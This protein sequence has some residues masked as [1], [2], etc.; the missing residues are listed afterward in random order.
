MIIGH[1]K[2]F[3]RAA[4]SPG[5]LFKGACLLVGGISGVFL[6]AWQAQFAALMGNTPAVSL[7]VLLAAAITIAI[8]FRLKTGPAQDTKLL[9]VAGTLLFATATWAWAF[10]YLIQRIGWAAHRWGT[11]LIDSP[12]A[13]FT[14]TFCAALVALGIPCLALAK[15]W[16]I[17]AESAGSDAAFVKQAG[18]LQFVGYSRVPLAWQV[19]GFG[20][21]LLVAGC[22][23]AP[24]LGIQ[25]TAMTAAVFAGVAGL[26]CLWQSV[27]PVEFNSEATT[28]HDADVAPTFLTLN[29]VRVATWIAL[30]V[31]GLI[32]ANWLRMTGQLFL[33][34]AEMLCIAWGGI[35]LGLA[36]GVGLG[37]WHSRRQAGQSRIGV[38]ACFLFAA[39]AVCLTA[40]FP[41][42]VK[43]S[44]WMNAYQSS[45]FWLTAGRGGILW[46]FCLPAGLTWG[47][48][49]AAPALTRSTRTALLMKRFALIPAALG[50]CCYRWLDLPAL[51]P[52][53]LA[54]CTAGLLWLAAGIAAVSAGSV[55]AGW[56]RRGIMLTSLAVI[57]ISPVWRTSYDP[58]LAAR[59]LFSTEIFMAY[60]SKFAIDELSQF[61]DARLHKLVEGKQGTYTLWKRRG[62][63]WQIRENGLSSTV[64]P[65]N[66]EL[67]PQ[68]SAEVL[69][70]I[71]PFLMHEHPETALFLGM[72]GSGALSSSLHFPL[73]EIVCVEADGAY[74]DL[75]QNEILP[76]T[77]ENPL[78]DD[79]VSVRQADPA[80]LA[81]AGRKLYDVIV[82]EPGYSS[83]PHNSAYFTAE[84]YQN[85]AN[86]LTADGIFAQ[87]F[88]YIDYGAEPLRVAA[89]TLSQA[90]AH[91]MFLQTAAGEMLLL[92]SNS[93]AGLVRPGLLARVDR[94]HVQAAL[95]GCGWDWSIVLNLSTHSQEQLTEFVSETPT[96]A[97][98]I[99]GGHFHCTLPREVI[100]W[101]NKMQ[102]VG[103]ALMPRTG[104]LLDQMGDDAGDPDVLE[105]LAEVTGKQKLIRDYPDQ[106]W[107][108]RSSVREQVTAGASGRSVIQQVKHQLAGHDFHP[109]DQR[110]MRYFAALG[111]AQKTK[112]P[113]DI[114]QLENFAFP[115]D[116]MITYFLHG[117]AAEL[118]SRA[119]EQRVPANELRH[120]LYST[121]YS[122]AGDRSV[123][124]IVDALNLLIEHPE[125]APDPLTRWDYINGLLQ[126]L[127]TRWYDRGSVQPKSFTVMIS[128]VSE[129]LLTA[130]RSLKAMRTI[131]TDAGLDPAVWAERERVLKRTLV[132]PLRDYRAALKPEYEKA[133]ATGQLIR[134]RVEGGAGE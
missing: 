55:F 62:S 52:A 102:E 109:R 75:M 34:S 114:R 115:Y 27:H 92:G 112:S 74:L 25:T 108:Y 20:C 86:Q 67:H 38:H 129:T 81:V 15:S 4:V 46:L 10:P 84:F 72:G 59:T 65:G 26:Y 70:G 18:Q 110:R 56:W 79:R 3:A 99:S 87:R 44:L 51:G 43:G 39:W 60:R 28:E 71:V 29:L 48:A 17:L 113:S 31:F 78:D 7:A 94:P 83:R 96:V 121:Y 134:D 42:L 16:S 19:G 23:L 50:F 93:E 105:H 97:N 69:P 124:T 106:Y 30:A 131:T 119:G 95:A 35:A 58:A 77:N 111:Q 85:F 130:D 118:Y 63:Q 89:K 41:L 61:D 98:T 11:S 53:V 33:I 88:R 123:R 57:A 1:L 122:V 100:R 128:D 13:A 103:I 40:A 64:L 9:T 68:F 116:P 24:W 126:V 120:R 49:I 2:K 90:F 80:L 6:W 125:A 21:G 73:T 117:E 14:F 8:G 76:T 104:R 133:K 37:I 82:S 47:L 22:G 5:S 132:K 101:A 12:T 54:T 45:R 91:V 36:S 32:T 107:A 66:T 127:Q